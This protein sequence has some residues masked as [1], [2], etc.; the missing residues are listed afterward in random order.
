M[1]ARKSALTPGSCA[2]RYH[3]LTPAL[4]LQRRGGA[5]KRFFA[6]VTVLLAAAAVRGTTWAPVNSGL[7][8]QIYSISSVTPGVRGDCLG[9]VVGHSENDRDGDWHARTPFLA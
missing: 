6:A 5:M 7:T 4:R 3:W 9:R 2:K 8:P 1:T